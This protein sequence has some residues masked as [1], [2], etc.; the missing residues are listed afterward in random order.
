MKEGK[1]VILLLLADP[2]IWPTADLWVDGPDR[3]AVD[4]I[5]LYPMAENG[6][7]PPPNDITAWF[8]KF[9]DRAYAPN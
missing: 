6:K 9:L 1:S 8:N 2:D 3:L 7:I 4:G 5:P